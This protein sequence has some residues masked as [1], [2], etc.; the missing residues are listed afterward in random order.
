MKSFTAGN[1]ASPDFLNGPGNEAS[2]TT[3]E[4]EVNAI[5]RE[6]D[7]MKNS[8][9]CRSWH[10]WHQSCLAIGVGCHKRGRRNHGMP[11]KPQK[12]DKPRLTHHQT[13]QF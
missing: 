5:E 8:G 9:K 3:D 2:L 7:K 1:T 11:L 12:A 13:E 10:T 6:K 4:V